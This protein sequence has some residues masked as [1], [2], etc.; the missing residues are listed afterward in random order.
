MAHKTSRR[1]GKKRTKQQQAMY[2]RRRIVFGIATVL[3]LSFIVFCLYSLTQ[4]S[5]LSTAEIHHADVCDLP[6]G[7]AVADPT[8]EKQRSRLRRINVALS[9]TPAASSFGVGGTMNFTAS[10]KYNGS[11]QGWLS[12]RRVPGGH[13][14]DDQVGQG[15]GLEIERMPRGHGLPADSQGRRGRAGDHLAGRAFRQ[16]MRRRGGPARMWTVACIRPNCRS[17]A[18]RKQVG[19]GRHHSGI[20]STGYVILMTLR[21]CVSYSGHAD[22]RKR[23]P[24]IRHMVANESASRGNISIRLASDKERPLAEATTNTTTI[25]ARAD[26]HDIDPH[27]RRTV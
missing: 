18:M 17:K 11:G 3:V 12:D 24:R 21:R 27:K 22:K 23:R 14:A 9:L 2:R 19:T 26:Q 10:V 8:A 1:T 6:Q 16:R 4:A 5:S 15:R 25:I 20:K 13:G 7:G